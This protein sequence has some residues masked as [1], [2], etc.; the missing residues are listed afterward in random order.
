[1]IRFLLNENIPSASV[2]V[3]RSA[4]LEVVSVME[5]CPGAGDTQVMELANREK[6]VLV[7]FDRDYGE[8]IYRRKLPPPHGVLYLRFIPQDPGEPGRYILSLINNKNIVLQGRFTVADRS[9]VRQRP[10]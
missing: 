1:M 9:Q 6:R 3:L 5:D 7:T 4:K 8:L 2:A 10:L